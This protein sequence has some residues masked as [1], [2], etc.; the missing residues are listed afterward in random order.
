MVVGLE[1][2]EICFGVDNTEELT[3]IKNASQSVFLFSCKKDS[4][5]A[6]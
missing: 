5:C 3:S 4:T 2:D 6:G 1:S